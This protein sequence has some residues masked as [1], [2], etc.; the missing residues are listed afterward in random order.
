MDI[1]KK[2]QR[3]FEDLD[4]SF[5]RVP[6]LA[7]H[8]VTEDGSNHDSSGCS[9]T[10]SQF[11]QQMRFLYDRGYQSLDLMGL[12]ESPLQGSS[13]QKKAFSL[14]FDDGFSDFCTNAFPILRYYG[15]NATVFLVTDFL[16][17]QSAW[18]GEKGT[19]MLTWENID[20]LS[21]SGISF[22]SH[23]CTHPYLL[24]L[25]DEEIWHEF[26]A[27]KKCLEEKLRSKISFIAYPFGESSPKIQQMAK[28]AGYTAAFGVMTGKPGRF[29][30]WRSECGA[31]DTLQT[32]SFKLTWLYSFF[33][34]TRGWV[35]EETPPGRILRKIKHRWLM[36][37]GH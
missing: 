21:A 31:Q 23:T 24:Q 4:L 26:T 36:H 34:K 3:L 9:I 10:K 32:F 27:S 7:Y 28:D 20:N 33:Q 6:V 14:T 30:W 18:D 15:F 5:I 8:H 37:S 22:G 13:Y 2:T 25:S 16:G 19:H 1:Q 12:L 11:K 29:N 35:R 17:R